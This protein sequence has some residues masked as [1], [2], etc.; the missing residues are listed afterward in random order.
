MDITEVLPE[1]RFVIL[2]TQFSSKLELLEAVFTKCVA[3]SPLEAHKADIWRTL[4][5]REK[6]MSTGIGLGVA[7]P[8]C[9]S[10]HV[11]DVTAFGAVLRHGVDFQAV[12]EAPVRIVVLLLMP[13][14]KFERHIKVLA[15]LAR[16]LNDEP[17]RTAVLTA[18]DAA[19]AYAA[20]A[21]QNAGPVVG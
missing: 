18:P 9:S 7:I 16:L 8:H 13:K 1:D 17:T 3:G 2:D 12:D 15:A 11:P 19:S 5:E 14:Q 20:L 4:V 6:S 10:E 21:R